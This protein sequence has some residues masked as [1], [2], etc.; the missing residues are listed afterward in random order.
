MHYPVIQFSVMTVGKQ[1]MFVGLLLSTA[2]FSCSLGKS[3]NSK[4]LETFHNISVMIFKGLE[5]VV[6]QM[7]NIGLPPPFSFSRSSTLNPMNSNRAY[8][9]MIFFT[10][11]DIEI[12]IVDEEP[13]F[14]R[15]Q[16]KLSVS[17]SP[18]KI[19]KV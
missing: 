7:K 4:K 10:D 12:E 9:K 5:L 8:K 19:V 3:F 2:F 1:V 13:A 11:E 18:V 14:L 17:M 6:S 15:G 16:T